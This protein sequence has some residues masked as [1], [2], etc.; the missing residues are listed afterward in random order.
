MSA[1][2]GQYSKWY[3]D[4]LEKIYQLDDKNKIFFRFESQFRLDRSS[5]V[6][7]YDRI[8]LIIK[9]HISHFNNTNFFYYGWELLTCLEDLYQ[10]FLGSEFILIVNNIDDPELKSFENGKIWKQHGLD[11]LVPTAARHRTLIDEFIKG[12]DYIS[13]V[14][15][16]KSIDG[17]IEKSITT[18]HLKN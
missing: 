11:F 14:R 18:Y 8:S 6:V 16:K 10:N 5:A 2:L 3:L 13:K 9:D 7:P 1:P 4:N 17:S 12:K 15:E